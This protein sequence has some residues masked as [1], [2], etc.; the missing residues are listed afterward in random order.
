MKPEI[1]F[2]DEYSLSDADL[3]RVRAMGDYRSYYN[4]LADEV[5][6]RVGNAEIVITNKVPF[7]RETMTA[8][9][10]LRLICVA[11]TGVNIIDLEAAAELGI[12]V[13][14]AAGYSTESVT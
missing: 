7:S 1:V 4:T 5:V 3:S 8:L 6:E 14:N 13:R 11:A 2:L 10:N 9:P 12:E